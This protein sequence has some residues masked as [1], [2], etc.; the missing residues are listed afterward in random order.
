[1]S[2]WAPVLERY[3]VGL[4]ILAILTYFLLKHW[5]PYWKTKDAQREADR[6]NQM[7]RM[8]NLQEVSIKEM[9][10]AIRAGSHQSEKIAEAM[11]ALTE[12]IRTNPR[13][14]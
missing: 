13:R 11:E 3:G 5:W 7:D 8:L 14:R 10:E 1:M 9:T 4:A 2:E 12:E 6:R